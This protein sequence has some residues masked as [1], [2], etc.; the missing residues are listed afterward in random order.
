MFSEV[1]CNTATITIM[2]I[3]NITIM[4]AEVAKWTKAQR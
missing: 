2:N 1:L 4:H 3:I